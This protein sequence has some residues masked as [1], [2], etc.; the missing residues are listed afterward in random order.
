MEVDQWLLA[1]E[2]G[3]FICQAAEGTES[4]VRYLLHL[5]ES[6]ADLESA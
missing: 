4:N 3:A 5:M 2:S 1:A 6:K